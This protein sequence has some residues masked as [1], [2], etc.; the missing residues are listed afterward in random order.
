MAPFPKCPLLEDIPD[1]PMAVALSLLG[2]VYPSAH[3]ACMQQGADLGEEVG[4]ENGS[5]KHST[6]W[7][8]NC[9]RDTC[10]SA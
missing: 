8:A 1:N 6:C 2:T 10:L 7:E 3:L 4:T 5:G 9:D